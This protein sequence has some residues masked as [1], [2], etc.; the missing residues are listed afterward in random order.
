MTPPLTFVGG[1]NKGGVTGRPILNS[2]VLERG[3][4]EQ[5]IDA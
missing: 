4:H 5:M 2:S 3:G 1:V